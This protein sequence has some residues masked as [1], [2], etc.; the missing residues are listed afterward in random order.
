ML[1]PAVDQQPQL[2]FGRLL[3]P[4]GGDGEALRGGHDLQDAGVVRRL[5]ETEL[6]P[7]AE[8]VPALGRIGMACLR[9]EAHLSHAGMEGLEACDLLS[10]HVVHDTA[11]NAYRES[12]GPQ[13]LE[14]HPAGMPGYEIAPFGMERHVVAAL[15]ASPLLGAGVAGSVGSH[16]DVLAEEVRRG[17]VAHVGRI[18]RQGIVPAFG[19]QRQREIAGIDAV[20][21]QDA[22]AYGCGAL[23]ARGRLLGALELGVDVS[24]RREGFVRRG[25]HHIGAEPERVPRDV[26]VLVRVQVDLLL[27]EQTELRRKT[28]R[29]A[30]RSSVD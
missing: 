8:F 13:G 11:L 18:G 4:Q 29:K 12:V 27:R 30:R 28:F 24:A 19:G 25:V 16:A 7:A 9:R 6:P 20:A 15:L 23:L 2:L 14:P 3:T 22:D 17:E 26:A 1:P 10:G 21:L 5:G